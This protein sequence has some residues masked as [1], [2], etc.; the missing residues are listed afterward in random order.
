MPF[1]GILQE[2]NFFLSQ[3]YCYTVLPG[4]GEGLLENGMTNS[5]KPSVYYLVSG[6]HSGFTNKFYYQS[7][8]VKVL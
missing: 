7:K 6:S 2:S 3:T 1:F 8:K 4:F 5:G